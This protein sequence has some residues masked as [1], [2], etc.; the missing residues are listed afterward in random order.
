MPQQLHLAYNS[1]NISRKSPMVVMQI[2]FL[3]LRGGVEAVVHPSQFAA[4][5]DLLKLVK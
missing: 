1:S 2:Y 5:A 3:G 4:V